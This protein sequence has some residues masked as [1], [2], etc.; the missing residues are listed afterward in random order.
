M[1]A[2]RDAGQKGDREE[3]RKAGRKGRT[4]TS[5]PTCQNISGSVCSLSVWREFECL[6]S[7]N[8][9]VKPPTSSSFSPPFLLIIH[10]SLSLSLSPLNHPSHPQAFTLPPS[11]KHTFLSLSATG[12]HQPTNQSLATSLHTPQLSC[13]LPQLYH[14]CLEKLS[15]FSE[16]LGKVPKSPKVPKSSQK[17]PKVPKNY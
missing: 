16:I 13:T 5:N 4:C 6:L 12:I 7:P 1:K 14:Y 2:G 10:L 11:S 17:F 9:Q 15:Y 3:S 8:L